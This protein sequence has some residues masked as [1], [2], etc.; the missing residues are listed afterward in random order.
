MREGKGK[1]RLRIRYAIKLS[2]YIRGF[3]I[4]LFLAILSNLAFK[5]LPLLTA[6]TVSYLVSALILGDLSGLWL[7]IGGIGALVILT[8]IFSYLD[9]YISHDMAYR[10]LT[11]LRNKCYAKLDEL[12]PAALV[13]ERS[14]DMISVALGDVETLEWFYAHTIGQIVVAF[15]VP[16]S[17]LIFMSSL[18][19]RLAA[20][21]LPFILILLMIPRRSAKLADEQGQRV[22]ESAGVLNAVIIDGVQGIK[23]II[24]FRWQKEYFQSFFAANEA[25]AEAAMD[26]A[27]RRADENRKILFVIEIAALAANLTAAFLV[28]QKRMEALWLLPIF[29]ISSA[30]FAP[31]LE[32]LSMSTNYGLIFAAARRMLRLFEMEPAVED[33]GTEEL[34]C[35]EGELRVSFE[36]L[37]FSYPQEKGEEENPP[38]LREMSFSFCRGETV[39]LVGASGSGKT[40][41]ARLLQRFWDASSGCIRINGRDIRD[42]PLTNLRAIVTVVPQEVYLFNRSILENLRLSRPGASDEEVRLAAKQAQ[43]ESFIQKLPKGY[44][45]L[46]GERGLRLSGGEKQRLSIAQA[47]LKNSP[48]LVLDEA[49]ANLDAENERMINEAVQDLK[50][51]RATLVIAHR[52]STIRSADRIVVLREGRVDCTGSYEELM[53]KSAYFCRLVG[54]EGGIEEQGD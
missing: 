8:A 31:I 21:I 28:I 3:H 1:E 51:G 16:L 11:D 53:E 48:I 37:S 22:K 25:C 18:S 2:K 14:G 45:T 26:Y 4:Y 40:T 10:I 12:A 17:A 33:R 5:I 39:A 47:F 9:V 43:A 6:L 41:A 54:E 50:K 42:L 34:D 13:G 32:A 7:Y 35:R 15:I 36:N 27:G 52:L 44:D 20:V 19:P 24:S 30:I 49:S 23:D 46:V 38:V 29:V